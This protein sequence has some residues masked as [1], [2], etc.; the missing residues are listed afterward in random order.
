MASYNSANFGLGVVGGFAGAIQSFSDGEFWQGIYRTS[1]S[2]LGGVGFGKAFGCQ[3]KG[4]VYTL[5]QIGERTYTG[6]GNP[7]HI[8]N[9]GST[10]K[11]PGPKNIQH[12]VAME[13]VKSNPLENA[14][15]LNIKMTDSR[16]RAEE[17]WVKMA[18]NIKGTEI[19][20]NYNELTGQ[21]DDFKFVRFK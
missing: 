13:Q 16:W 5:T 7:V 19:H 14:K 8:E 12:Q 2:A 11:I 10:A 3:V 17:G 1:L 6:V 21:F 18:T 9:R 4:Y 15:K 20:F